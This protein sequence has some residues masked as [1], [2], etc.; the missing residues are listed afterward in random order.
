MTVNEVYRFLDQSFPFSLALE[1][2]NCGLLIGDSSASVT[3]AVVAL[4]CT[5]SALHCAL[6]KN[7][8]LLITHHPVIFD[9]IKSVTEE[10]I[11]FS[12]IK[13]GVAVISAH[14]NL[15]TAR[16]G[17]NDALCDALGLINVTPVACEDGFTFRKGELSTAMPAAKLA[18]YAAKR[19][20][21]NA[22]FVDG[23]REIKTVAVCSGSG[24]SV[25]YDAY[26]S[27]VDAFISSEIK[28]NLF[29]TAKDCGFSVFDL[30][31]EATELPVVNK[32]AEKLNSAISGVEFIPFSEQNIDFI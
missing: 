18:E 7:A 31:H 1:F 4:D 14:T 28:H 11:V 16:G 25:F 30:G 22:R 19:L 23:G 26:L 13:Q 20:N 24:S 15:D 3:R 6:E 2:D 29:L 17:V 27:G 8:Q 10:S 32:L 21:I 9:G 12:A 5:K